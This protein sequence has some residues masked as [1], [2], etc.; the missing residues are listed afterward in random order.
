VSLGNVL[1]A[2]DVSGPVSFLASDGGDQELYRTW[3]SR[4]F[5]VQVGLHELL[6][7]GSGKVL[8]EDATGKL[9]F[10]P[11]TTIDPA[12]GAPVTS[13]YKPGERALTGSETGGSGGEGGMTVGG[14]VG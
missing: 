1:A 10:D 7:H 6:G 14:R 13:W 12:T 9:N 3:L 4:A 2:R 11:A 8:A 5:E